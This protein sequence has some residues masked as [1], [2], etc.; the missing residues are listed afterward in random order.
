M[1]NSL[2]VARAAAMVICF[3]ALAGCAANQATKEGHLDQYDDLVQ[4]ADKKASV[5]MRPG[6]QAADFAALSVDMVALAGKSPR[7]AGLTEEERGALQT[8]LQQSLERA[9]TL[10]SSATGT[11]AT[12]AT[13]ARRA[14]VR[15][16]I[17]DFDAPNSTMNVVLA[18]VLIPMSTGG[19]SME[20]EVRDEANGQRLLAMTCADAG[21]VASWQGMKDAFGRLDHAKSVMDLCADRLAGKWFGRPES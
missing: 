5:Y 8:H 1:H 20:F 12:P 7:M 6:L 15:A 4:S 19:A 18:I 13:G 21:S 16:A 14:R 2:R 11:V 10:P 17:T 3:V 9:L